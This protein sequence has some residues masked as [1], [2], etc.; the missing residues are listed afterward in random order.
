M[1]ES[2]APL[3]ET[4]Q[5]G[6]RPTCTHPSSVL[7]QGQKILV[8]APVSTVGNVLGPVSNVGNVYTSAN[9]A[10]NPSAPTVVPNVNPFYIRFIE[11]N[12]RMCQGCKSF[13]RRSDGSIPAPPFDLCAARAERRSFRDANGTLRTPLKEQPAHYHLNLPCIRTACPEFI[14]CSLLVPSDVLPALTA[15]HKEYLRLVF[16]LLNL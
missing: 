6:F 12:I 4:N 2:G 10:P 16:G 11:G 7:F 14:P 9:A 13:L 15:V 3:S 1:I 5:V 8:N